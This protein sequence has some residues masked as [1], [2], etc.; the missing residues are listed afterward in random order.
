MIVIEGYQI[1]KLIAKG[2][3][4]EVFLAYDENCGRQIALKKIRADL[5]EHPHLQKRF[6]KEAYLTCQLAH[7]TIIPIY[8]IYEE[9]KNSYYTMPFVEGET[10]KYVLKRT[11]EQ[12]GLEKKNSSQGSISSLVRIFA[13]ICQGIAYAH[14]KGILH[15]DIKPENIIIGK[16]GEVLILD[17][18]LAKF[19]NQSDEP[20]EELTSPKAIINARSDITRIG[21]AVG[22]ISYMAPEIAMGKPGTIQTDVYALGAILYQ[23]LALRNPFKRGKKLEDF[24]KM[25]YKEELIDPL[26]LAPHRDI[27]KALSNIAKKCLASDA[28]QRYQTMEDLI[29]DLN[30]YLEGHSDWFKIAQLD[31]KTKNDW[32]FQ[33]NI[34]IAGP[35][36]ITPLTAEATWVM[37]MISRSSF[38][39]N[40]KLETEVYLGDRC[41]G[42]GF[43]LGVPETLL[44]SHIHDGY[45]MWLGSDI[46]PTTQL[47]RSHAAVMEAPDICLKRH[48]WNRIRIEKIENTLHLYIND[49]LQFSYTAH[50]PFPG[51]HIGLLSKDADFEV[52]PIKISIGNLNITESCLAVPD[53]FLTRKYFDDAL[54]EYRR[55]ANSFPDRAEGRE[56][57]FRSGLTLIEQSKTNNRDSTYLD[58]ALK[59]FEKLH[60]TPG[61]PLEYLGKALVYSLLSEHEEEIKCFELAYRRYPKH[62]LLPLLQDQVVTRTHEISSQQ[63]VMAYRFIY[64]AIRHLPFSSLDVHTRK[65][66]NDLHQNWEPLP[67]IEKIHSKVVELIHIHF[68]IQLA[69]WLAKPYMV[70][71]L[72]KDLVKQNLSS[73]VELKNALWSLIELNHWDLFLE[74][75]TL[76]HETSPEVGSWMK[77]QLDLQ[78]HPIEDLARK[79]ASK[80]RLE[81]SFQEARTLIYW[82]DQALDRNQPHLVP[83]ISSSLEHCNIAF[84][85]QLKF[86]FRLIWAYLLEKNWKEAEKILHVYPLEMLNNQTTLLYFLYGCW[87][88]GIGESEIA[89]IHFA[90]LMPQKYPRSWMLAVHYIMKDLDPGWEAQSFEW[91]REQLKRQLKLYHRCLINS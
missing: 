90:G 17:W 85:V 48:L 9:G 79:I 5:D 13:T 25:A 22:T 28:L 21:K 1:I 53:A 52:L 54:I 8:R 62:P 83:L 31:I 30:I 77:E 56:A 12:E 49:R 6:L 70:Q 24:K 37:M 74:S 81:I 41:C 46:D 44:R 78:E 76:I 40:L 82:M 4:G 84:E 75:L 7:P 67:F 32:E 80:K 23:I 39:G 91:E 88:E 68:G 26:L 65:L 45:C 71:E 73:F 58:R 89:T 27:P 10:L 63:R 38:Q 20:E 34:L 60:R 69:F 66:L 35:T 55:I 50:L 33:E 51:T 61:A 64:L 16:Y 29:N 72:I 47:L 18:G 14:S 42:I 11:K 2:G 57:I 36:A 15:R 87:L 19:L 59:E 3:M 43:L 86:N